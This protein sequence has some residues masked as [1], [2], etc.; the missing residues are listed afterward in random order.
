MTLQAWIAFALLV[1]VLS[2]T[3][4]PAVLLVLSQALSRG[5]GRTAWTILG[6]IAA[7]T[8]YFALSTTG[9]GALLA[10]SHKLF[11]AIRWTG[12]AYLVVIGALEIFSASATHTVKP[13]QGGQD[14]TA[15]FI[16]G[17]VLQTSSP[18]AL[19]F[20]VAVIP[21]FLNLKAPLIPQA[22]LLAVTG[23][24]AELVVLSF[25]AVLVDRFTRLVVQGRFMTAMHRISGAMLMA[26]GAGMAFFNS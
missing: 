7:N 13:A 2:L 25:Y 14:K 16:K 10:A 5:M 21:Q 20:F 15:M 8:L 6:I 18:A 23:N 19:L 22:A 11:S 24:A 4:G 17:F 1:T 26:A 12:A 9:L 3:P